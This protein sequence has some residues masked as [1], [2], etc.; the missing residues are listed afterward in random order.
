MGRFRPLMVDIAPQYRGRTLSVFAAGQAVWAAANTFI[1]LSIIH[2][3]IEVFPSRKVRIICIATMVVSG[4]Y[5]TSV[6]LETF[7]LC[8]PVQFNWDKKTQDPAANIVWRPTSFPEARIWS[9]MS[10]L[11]CY[12]CLRC[13][14]C[15][16]HSYY[17]HVWFGCIVSFYSLAPSNEF[18]GL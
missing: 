12:P 16:Y 5:F 7:L 10:S 6:L 14:N 8:T 3:Y 2:L 11:L 17:G 18:H 4:F 13:G 9:S 1:K 15:T